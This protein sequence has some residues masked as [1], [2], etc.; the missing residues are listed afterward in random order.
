[1]PPAVNQDL[2]HI[3]ED[4][5][6]ALR[7]SVPGASYDIWLGGLEPEGLDGLVLT[8]SAPAELRGWIID[9]YARVL[10]AAAAAAL[11]EGARLQV[12]SRQG[13][14]GR[15]RAAPDPAT[16]RGRPRR[17]G[18]AGPAAPG[19]T[20]GGSPAEDAPARG[21]LN[22]KLTF[23]Q[24]VIGD[25]NHLAHAAAL[26]V[27]ELPGQAYNPLFVYGPPGVGKTHLL[28]SIG[29]Y[30]VASGTGLTV[31]YTTAERFTNE[32]ITSLRHGSVDHL[33]GRYRAA[34][35]LLIDDVQF[36][37]SKAKTEEEFFHTFNALYDAG[38]QLVL[39]SD[40]LPADLDALE[41]RLRERFESGLVTDIQA[42]DVATRM[43][44]LRKRVA[45]D[46]I[47]LADPD[48]L[49]VIA[50]RIP[51][52]IRAL[53]GALIR[54]VAFASLTDRPLTPAVAEEVL[55]GLY[56][57]AGAAP[58]AGRAAAPST[59]RIS[60]DGVIDVVCET[61]SVTRE[62]LLSSSRA[63]RLAWPRQLAMH[64]AREHTD[65]SLPAIGRHFGG[66][67]HTT[68]MYAL[69]RTVERLAADPEALDT[70]QALSRRLRAGSVPPRPPGSDRRP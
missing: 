60:V 55:D 29:N 48:V 20:S 50:E 26:S 8:A 43:T 18:P 5:R 39:T 32:F 21:E 34:D 45:H 30:V 70:E 58:G 67:K 12:V 4:V 37:E 9:R 59:A 66:R 36:L 61:F 17:A 51:T 11:G 44:V 64:L 13:R 62:D 68:V 14:A 28:H 25:G 38:A 10:D 47:Q 23:G 19:D 7:R 49:R 46:G 63:A 53:E 31:R 15:P 35:V 40:R 42:P 22:P 52:N 1:M 54:V 6:A 33:R 16:G 2:A 57:R 24:F 65:A 3:W 56:P 41:D 69:K 27:A